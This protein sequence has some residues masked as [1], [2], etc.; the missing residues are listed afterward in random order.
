M[1]QK[2]LER[3]YK[4]AELWHLDRYEG[5]DGERLRARVIASFIDREVESI[6]DVG[7]GNGFVT[8]HLQGNRVVGLDP[9]KEALAHF[10]GESVVGVAESL[11][12]E[13]RSFDAIVCAEVLEHLTDDVFVKAVRELDRV[14]KRFLIIGV[15]YRQDLR[16]GMTICS[17]CHTRY[18][19]HLHKRSFRGPEDFESVFPEFRV[20]ATAL[21]CNRERIRSRFFRILRYRLVGPRAHSP[22]A[23]CPNCGSTKCREFKKTKRLRRWFFDGLAWRMKKTIVPHWLIVLLERRSS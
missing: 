21:L 4:Q 23:R 10:E 18:H 11:P 16:E 9:S 14:A 20:K 5:S 15:P 1:D 8:R 12:F 19:V 7:C 3:Y 6:L 17:D 13:D 22:L 2:G